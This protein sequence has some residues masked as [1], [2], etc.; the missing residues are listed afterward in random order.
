MDVEIL[1][2]N[3]LGAT[4]VSSLVG[5]YSV[6]LHGGTSQMIDAIAVVYRMFP[7]EILVTGLRLFA[8]RPL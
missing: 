7:L 2:S 1:P 4:P 8:D 6:Y 3:A 5:N